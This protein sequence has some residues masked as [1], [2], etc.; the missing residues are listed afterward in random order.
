MSGGDH[1]TPLV[2]RL[3]CDSMPGRRDPTRFRKKDPSFEVGVEVED[4]EIEE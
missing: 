2:F 1:A 4:N 3:V